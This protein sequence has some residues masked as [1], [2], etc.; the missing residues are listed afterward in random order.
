MS[1]DDATHFHARFC[2]AGAFAFLF[3]YTMP[4]LFSMTSEERKEARYQRRKALREAKRRA[5]IQMYDSYERVISANSLIHAE[6]QSRKSVRFKASVQRYDMNL[7]RQT[8]DTRRKL[9][10]GK[11]VTMGFICFSLCERGKTRNI[12]SVHFKERVVQRSLCD[13]ALV[14]VLSRSLDDDNGASQKGKGIHFAINR[15]KAHLQQYY[16]ENG[17]SNQG[18]VLQVDYSG[19]FDHIQHPPIYAM[20]DRAFTDKRIVALTKTFVSCF[21]EES[22]GLGSQVSQILAVAYPTPID[23]CARQELHLHH[24]MRYMDDS[25]YFHPSKAYLEICLARL[26]EQAAKLGIRLNEKKTKII[27][28]EHFTYL[29]VRFTLTKTGRVIMKPCRESIKR[30]RRKI[31]AFSG[32]IEAGE[33]TFTQANQSHQSCRGYIRHLNSHRSI[34][35]LDAHFKREITEGVMKRVHAA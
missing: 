35:T 21:G 24:S 12:R 31:K 13:N 32:K 29:K 34:K 33:M 6:R 5:A 19:Y 7:L 2:Y 30:M 15:C 10:A 23:R 14:P 11:N 22:L 4:S 16:R 28:I 27:P 9:K 25:Q 17:F 1:G 20:L 26:K 18:W 3:L 8:F